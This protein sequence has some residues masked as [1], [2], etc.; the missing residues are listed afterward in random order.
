[1]GHGSTIHAKNA[2]I[3]CEL[4]V[5]PRSPPTV[6]YRLVNA[7]SMRTKESQMQAATHG[8]RT[9]ELRREQLLTLQGGQGGRVRLLCGSALLTQEGDVDETVL[10]AGRDFELH[11]GLTVI[12]ATQPARLQIVPARRRPRGPAA[13]LRRW[14]QR[15][16]LGPVRAELAA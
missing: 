1:M 14:R 11:D 10:A 7:R 13:A 15:L 2:S 6:Q 5:C 8:I 4:F 16:Q 12:E 3:N 9:I